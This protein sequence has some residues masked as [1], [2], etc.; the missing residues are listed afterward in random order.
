VSEQHIDTA[1]TKMSKLQKLRTFFDAPSIQ[2]QSLMSLT[3]LHLSVPE[4]NR[5]KMMRLP[6]NLISLTLIGTAIIDIS[7]LKNNLLHLQQLRICLHRPFNLW[8]HIHGLPYLWAFSY[9]DKQVNSDIDMR[10]DV[11]QALQ[12]AATW[13]SLRYLRLRTSALKTSE[14][15]RGLTQI[16]ELK[17]HEYGM[18]EFDNLFALPNLQRLTCDYYLP[19][20]F[21]AIDRLHHGL[22]FCFPK[23]WTSLFRVV[24]LAFQ[25]NEDL[26]LSHGGY[27][28][29]AQR[30]REYATFSRQEFTTTLD[31]GKL[32][33]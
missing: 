7:T 17:L 10:D 13:P 24:N 27:H 11:I 26:S 16:T 9:S 29:A 32:F 18:F 6:P 31:D 22:T 1:F 33:W 28:S 21:C 25:R 4:I 20:L 12:A 8:K 14:P 19:S 23:A 30:S 5:F 3:H 15:F 2:M